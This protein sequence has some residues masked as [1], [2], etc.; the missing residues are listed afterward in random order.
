MA[1][2]LLIIAH[3]ET[4]GTRALVF[5][6]DSVPFVTV[7]RCGVRVARWVSAPDPACRTTADQLGTDVTTA[8]ELAACDFGRWA[9]RK[10]VDVGVAE[11]EAVATWLSDPYAAPHGG[12]SLSALL[13]RVR[14]FL[15]AQARRERTAVAITHGGVVKAAVVSALQAPPAAF[16]RIDVAPLAIT[17]LHAHDGRW[18][19]TRVNDR[20]EAP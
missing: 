11:P 6:D 7:G 18:T 14:A 10:L 13:A 16:W 4:P 8:D 17:E 2:R 19:V 1:P 20:E 3:A 12:E 15:A 5:G 9:G